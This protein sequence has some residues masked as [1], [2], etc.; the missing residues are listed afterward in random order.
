MG[1]KK[2]KKCEKRRK[3]ELG[4]A[5]DC[6]CDHN[7][8][9]G[10]SSLVAL[11]W[12]LKRTICRQ[13]SFGSQLAVTSICSFLFIVFFFLIFH[14]HGTTWV[15]RA[16]NICDL[17]SSCFWAAF[18]FLSSVSPAWL[19]TKEVTPSHVLSLS[20]SL[21]ISTSFVFSRVSSWHGLGDMLV[22]RPAPPIC[23]LLRSLGAGIYA[24]RR[25]HRTDPSSAWQS[26]RLSHAAALYPAINGP[27]CA[28]GFLLS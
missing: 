25:P 2:K 4:C 26:C 22:H 24:A 11:R 9:V 7:P 5:W 14:K 28:A 15:W 13:R 6:G 10:W 12:F 1:V 16:H 23:Y 20:P 19:D 3:V 18:F 27:S 8:H 17:S 21:F